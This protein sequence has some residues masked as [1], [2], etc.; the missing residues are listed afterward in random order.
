MQRG[1]TPPP[2]QLPT[3]P[4]TP[5][6]SRPPSFRSSRSRSRSRAS[7]SRRSENTV[8]FAD[9]DKPLP[10]CPSVSRLPCYDQYGFIRVYQHVP[11]HEQEA[12]DAKYLYVCDRRSKK[13]D[14]WVDRHHGALPPRSDKLKRYIRKGIPHHLRASCWFHYS[15]AEAKWQKETELYTLLICREEQDLQSGYSKDDNEIFEHITV[16]DRGT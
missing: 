8:V 1:R 5:P 2:L 16:I 10:P 4:K 11:H 9:L 14:D 13:W 3:P 6:S 12:I 15:G 7:T